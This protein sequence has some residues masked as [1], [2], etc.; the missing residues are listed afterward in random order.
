MDYE[1]EWQYINRLVSWGKY[2]V[3]YWR[4]LRVLDFAR[5]ESIPTEVKLRFIAFKSY[6]DT[7]F[8]GHYA[9]PLT[10]RINDDNISDGSKDILNQI[11]E[12]KAAGDEI[13]ASTLAFNTYR[14]IRATGEYI[15]CYDELVEFIRRIAPGFS[16]DD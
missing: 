10:S 8:P 7:T 6:I 16:P 2:A 9:P 13:R 12:A 14:R 5:D 3:A 4:C 11:Y 15:E 1:K